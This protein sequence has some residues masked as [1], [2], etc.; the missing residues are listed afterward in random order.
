M[1][2]LFTIL[3]SLFL[4]ISTLFAS[5]SDKSAM[6]YYGDDISYSMVGIHD[7]IIVQP[8]LINTSRHGFS[9][10]KDKIYAYVSI[11]EID[12][13]IKEFKKVKK[14]WIVATNVAW[15]SKVLDIKNKEYQEFIFKEL[16][17]PRRKEGFVNFFFD[18]LDS[19]HL[20]S[21]TKKEKEM[22]RK[23]LASFI[24]EFH[25]RYPEAKLI[26]NRGFDIIDDVHDSIEAVLFESYYV[27]VGGA[28]LGYKEVSDNDREWLD[29]YIKKI[30]SYHKDVIALEYL[31]TNQLEQ[32]SPSI[33]KKVKEKGMIPYISNVD[34]TIY[35][36]SSKNAIK[37]EILTLIDEKSLDRT[38]LE[39]H[40]H[41][42]LIFEYL[43]YK[44]KLYNI[45]NGFPDLNKMQQYK[46]VVVWL[47]DNYKNQKELSSWI[48][49]VM[50]M[51]M[52][53]VFVKDFG[54]LA[55]SELLKR[56]G[57]RI[58]FQINQRVKIKTKDK[59][60]GYEIEPSLSLSQYRVKAKNITKPL[61]AYKLS[62][63]KKSTLSAITTWGG[64]ALEDGFMVELKKDNLWVIN[65]FLFFKE[66]LRLE[67]LVVPDVTTENG[68]RLLF[69]HIDGD[70][71][72]NQVEGRK[73]EGRKKAKYSG[74]VIYKDILKSYKIPHSVSVIGAEIDK[75][76][77]YPKLSSKM[78]DIVKKIYAL[79]NVEAATHTYTHPFY[80]SQIKND[81]LPLK[82]R[83]KVKNYNFSLNREIK[84]SLQEINQNLVKKDRPRAKTVFWTGDCA[85][86]SNALR[87]TYQNGIFNINGG[88]TTITEL[89][90]WL[91]N[92]APLGLE[93]DGYYQIYTGAQNE[94]V[95]TNDWL[96]PFW[97]FKRVVQTF[98]LTNSPRRFKPIDIYYHLYSGSKKASLK[99]LKYVFDWA[100]AQDVNPIYTS[101]YIPKV[102]DFYEVSMANEGD[103]WLIDG[104]RDLKTLRVEQKD[105]GVDLDKSPSVIGVKHFE[106]H[107]YIALD[108][109]KKHII[110]L[111][112][113]MSKKESYMVSVNGK[114]ISYKKKRK[115]TTY[116]L[117]SEV[118]LKA[119]FY[120][121][122][123]CKLKA[124]PMASSIKTED[125]IISLEYKSRKKAKISILCH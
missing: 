123:G 91:T 55:N 94:N 106:N 88:D 63:G 15:K 83:L 54:G 90:P 44:Q 100:V 84:Q 45:D 34:L 75:D 62:N 85:P 118:P 65:P 107:T 49:Q 73:V 7:Y 76:G 16:I 77:L 108:K 115:K 112:P 120:L 117:S 95:F 124:K 14:S 101:E 96:G 58:K 11:G 22:S 56:I 28:N 17:E 71:I 52:K 41:G 18:T 86:R 72:M 19:Y 121:A 23:A 113:H 104:M 2:Y 78:I 89:T 92:I 4:T 5:L 33:I 125:G 47:R 61:L 111:Q 99:A 31:P 103:E 21:Q 66:A 12:E 30:Q 37:R 67:P 74:E 26:L 69:T 59:M 42:A 110:K 9:L 46:G 119:E 53:V 13:K 43:G 36:K 6:V 68:K 114:V 10:Y 48:L 35:G 3:I 79:P 98:K 60:I 1:K 93:R 57:L 32:K 38:L 20:Y 39:A 40:Q 51:N 122:K 81:F 82:Y 105:F 116:K 50:K 109:E 102:M 87:H 80:W 8:E 24:N 29:I 25:K 97:G 27:G 64:Y 70:G